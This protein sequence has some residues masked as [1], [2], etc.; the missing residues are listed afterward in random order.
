MKERFV[1]RVTR[2]K[3]P[4]PNPK[5]FEKWWVKEESWNGE[6]AKSQNKLS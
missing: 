5:G 3:P 1:D 2:K 4:A 6:T